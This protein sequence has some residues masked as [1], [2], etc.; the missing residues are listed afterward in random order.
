MPRCR[1]RFTTAWNPFFTRCAPKMS[2]TLASRARAARIPAAQSRM[3]ARF[4][5]EHGGPG[6]LGS[7]KISSSVLSDLRSDRAN[8]LTRFRSSGSGGFLI[9]PH[10]SPSGF[11]CGLDSP[12]GSDVANLHALPQRREGVVPPGH[13]FLRH[14]SFEAGLQNRLHDAR[15]VQLLRFINLVAPRHTAG[16]IMRDELVV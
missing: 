4:S 8:T 6:W 11:F 10:P 14:E 15:I 5:A 7:T 2:V 9:E 16:V 12:R 13:K 3:M 1:S